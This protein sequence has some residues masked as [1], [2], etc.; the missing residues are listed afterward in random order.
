MMLAPFGVCRSARWGSWA[1]GRGEMSDLEADA[2]G[3]EGG[4]NG[5]S[6]AGGREDEPDGVE[7]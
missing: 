6:T 4:T 3:L 2:R 5:R 1:D 7:T